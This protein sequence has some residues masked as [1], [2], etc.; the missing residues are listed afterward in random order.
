MEA[1]AHLTKGLEVLRTLPDTLERTQQELVL[2]ITLGSAWIATRGYAAPEV[3]QAYTRALELCRQVGETPRLLQALFGLEAFYFFRGELQTARE[4]GEQGLLLAQRLDDP[5]RCLLA[6]YALGA[7]LFHLGELVSARE[8]HERVIAL[9]APQ[10]RPPRA[11]QDPGVGSRSYMAWI[12][13]YLGYADQ[14]LERSREA[15]TLAQELS[16]PF[17]LA[18][19]LD[20]AAWLQQCCR[21]RQAVQEQAEAAM[22]LCTEQGF[23]YWLA[24]AMILRGWALAEQGQGE[25][26][27]VQIRQGL[28]SYQATGAKLG[29]P[30][31]LALLT[32]A[33]GRAGQTEEGLRVLAEALAAMDQKGE[34]W[35]EA[36]LQ[37]L[38]GTLLLPA[39][40]R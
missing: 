20:L 38:Q 8:H 13:W 29:R 36:E 4:L 24:W 28:A 10:R 40:H 35:W 12:L 34:R 17:S 27:M 9:Y 5:A 23:P 15:V 7:A 37:R 6:D 32:E 19:A 11:V 31:F 30:Y 2:Q 33:Y 1:I 18:V 3:E 14:A 16:H 21:E 25:E 22:T 39:E 26:G